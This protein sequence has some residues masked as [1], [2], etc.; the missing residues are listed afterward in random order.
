[1]NLVGPGPLQEHFDDAFQ[2]LSV[3][4]GHDISGHYADLGTGAGF[5]G[6]VFAGEH[7]NVDIDLVD[8]RT[9]R[10]AFL[11]RVLATAPSA[12][13]AVVRCARVESIEA[14]AYDGIMARAFAP[15]E[16]VAGHALRLL[17]PGGLAVLLVGPDVGLSI[18]GL[19]PVRQHDYEVGA[20]SRRVLLLKRVDRAS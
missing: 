18:D 1:M 17:R 13:G 15:P 16:D 10:C 5:P 12:T 14:G 2:A 19:L 7:P 11:Q 6:L 20:R 3:L 4:E 8:S 9:K